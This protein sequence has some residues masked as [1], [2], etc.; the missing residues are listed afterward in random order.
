[1]IT[2][3]QNVCPQVENVLG[4]LKILSLQYEYHIDKIGGWLKVSILSFMHH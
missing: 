4:D 1:M 3:W 2:H